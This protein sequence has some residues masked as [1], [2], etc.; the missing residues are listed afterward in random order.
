MIAVGSRSRERP[1]PH[2]Q[3]E[4]LSRSEDQER[5][6]QG[7]RRRRPGDV[8]LD[9]GRGGR[10]DRLGGDRVR[11]LLPDGG[12]HRSARPRKAS[13]AAE[14]QLPPEPRERLGVAAGSLVRQGLAVHGS[15][16]DLDDRDRVPHRQG[17]EDAPR[18][19]EPVR[20]LLG[21][22]EQGEDVPPRRQPRCAGAHA[23]E[24]RDLEHQHRGCRR[25]QAREGRAQVVDRRGQHQA[26]DGRLHEPAGR[27]GVG[28]PDVVG[29]RGL[30]PVVSAGRAS[31]RTHSGTG[32]PRTG[33]GRSGAT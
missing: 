22:G 20:D 14:R 2:L 26:L 10:E 5:L 27:Q 4:R 11:R 1:A 25:H 31:V 6:R 18:L 7:V 19:L 28:A 30:R 16:H 21:R 32:S 29:K 33:T 15:V 23:A 24:E 8:L 17:L 9:D 3:L 13:P 12:S